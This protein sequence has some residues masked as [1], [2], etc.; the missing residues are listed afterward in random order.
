MRSANNIA[1]QLNVLEQEFHRQVVVRLDASHFGRRE[2]DKS[3][4]LFREKTIHI[5]FLPQIKL[6]AIAGDQVGKPLV[7]EFADKCASDQASMTGDEYFVRLFHKRSD[8]CGL[9]F[10]LLRRCAILSSHKTARLSDHDD[11]LKAPK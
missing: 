3:R 10:S 5:R 7:P 9:P 6:G 11:P 1:L 8:D 2:D 4:L